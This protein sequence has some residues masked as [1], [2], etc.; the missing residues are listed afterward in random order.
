MGPVMMARSPTELV[1]MVARAVGALI[2]LTVGKLTVFG[3]VGLSLKASRAVGVPVF[4]VLEMWQERVVVAQA[5]P[6]QMQHLSLQL[7]Q[8]GEA[9][10]ETVCLLQLQAQLSPGVAGQGG[11]GSRQAE[12]AELV[13]AGMVELQARLGQLEQQTR[14]GAGEVLTQAMGLTVAQVWSSSVFP[15]GQA[16][17]FQQV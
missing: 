11:V 3:A 9:M 16:F 4:V 5:Q 2:S 1:L 7:T 6:A 12:P 15:Q 10:A 13:G 8:Q 17:R 14:A